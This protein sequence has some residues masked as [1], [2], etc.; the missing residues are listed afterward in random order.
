MPSIASGWFMECHL[1]GPHQSR[2][3]CLPASFVSTL[4]VSTSILDGQRSLIRI[5]GKSK[6]PVQDNAIQTV[7]ST[8]QS[9]RVHPAEPICHAGSML[10]NL[11]SGTRR[12]RHYC[13]L[14]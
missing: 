6:I 2:I 12:D 8:A 11:N 4:V 7:V 3:A 10:A 5:L 14:L 1:S 9:T 13:V